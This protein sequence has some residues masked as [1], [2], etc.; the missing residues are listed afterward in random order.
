MLKEVSA[1]TSGDFGKVIKID[2]DQIEKDLGEMV[3]GS[4]EEDV[5]DNRTP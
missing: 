4:V 1:K 3:R 2:F 5:M